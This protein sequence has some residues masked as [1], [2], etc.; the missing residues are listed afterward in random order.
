MLT[1]STAT[2]S[3]NRIHIAGTLKAKIYAGI[4]FAADVKP[5]ELFGVVCLNYSAWGDKE[6]QNFLQGS[7]SPDGFTIDASNAPFDFTSI[8][9]TYAI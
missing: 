8:D 2:Q 6:Y 4:S 1:I 9:F 7:L 5:Q 3:G